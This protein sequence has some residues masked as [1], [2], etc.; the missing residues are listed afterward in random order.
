MPGDDPDRTVLADS[1]VTPPADARL[2]VGSTTHTIN[3]PQR[4]G[5]GV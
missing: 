4:S 2:P 5:L 3:T 1:V